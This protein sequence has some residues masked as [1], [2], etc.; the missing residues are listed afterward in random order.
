MMATVDNSNTVLLILNT[1]SIRAASSIQLTNVTPRILDPSKDL[2][3][4]RTLGQIRGL[5]MWMLPNPNKPLIL[6]KCIAR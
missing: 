1:L 6:K 5:R 2:K 4:P 3:T